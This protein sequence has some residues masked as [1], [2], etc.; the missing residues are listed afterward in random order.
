MLGQYKAAEN[1]MKVLSIIITITSISVGST[2][3][4]SELYEGDLYILLLLLVL[5]QYKA[6]YY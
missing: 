1:C 3:G 5:G 6:N 4:S 2:Q